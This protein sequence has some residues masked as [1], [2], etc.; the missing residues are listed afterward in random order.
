MPPPQK[1]DNESD[2]DPDP[3]YPRRRPPTLR[4]TEGGHDNKK[5]KTKDSTKAGGQST[6]ELPLQPSPKASRGLKAKTSKRSKQNGEE[7]HS[8]SESA[9]S[10]CEEEDDQDTSEQDA[11]RLAEELELNLLNVRYAYGLKRWTTMENH[12][13]H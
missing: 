2:N 10:M 8:D 6:F 7:G 1:S 5:T 4:I 13:Q 12:G 9:E 3:I 11:K